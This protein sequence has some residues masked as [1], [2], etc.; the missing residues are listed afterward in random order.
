MAARKKPSNLN[1]WF[2]KITARDGLTVRQ[3]A[4]VDVSLKK[5]VVP[6]LRVDLLWRSAKLKRA[7][8][9]L[10]RRLHPK[11]SVGKRKHS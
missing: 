2:K 9:L 11:E 1:D 8:P 5:V 4:L 3:V 7:K 6:I 10:K